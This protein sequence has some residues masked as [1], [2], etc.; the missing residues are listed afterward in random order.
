MSKQLRVFSFIES[1]KPGTN[2]SLNA[3]KQK[4][5]QKRN[6]FICQTKK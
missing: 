2:K 5:Q 1:L 3:K 4:N 6:Y